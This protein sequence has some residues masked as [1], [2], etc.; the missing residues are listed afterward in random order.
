MASLVKQT[1]YAIDPKTGEK[2]AKKSQC[3]Y[4]QYRDSDGKWVR[5]KAHKDKAASQT[6]L[7]KIVQEAERGNYD[8][9]LKHSRRPL[10]EHLQDFKQALANSGTAKNAELKTARIQRILDAGKI[11]YIKDLSASAVQET[12]SSF[13]KIVANYRSGRRKETVLPDL[14]S[15]KSKSHYLKAIK[16]FCCWLVK[17]RRAAENPLAY[18]TSGRIIPTQPRRAMTADQVGRLLQSTEAARDWRG[19]SGPERAMLYRLAVETGL[20]S[21]EL[22]SLTVGDF[23]LSANVVRLAGKFAKNRNDVALPLR[24]ATVEKLKTFFAGKLPGAAVFTM[25]PSEI[26]SAMIQS[27]LR[28]AGIDP[29]DDGTGKLDFHALRHTFATLLIQTGVDIKS[30]QTLLRHSSP[31]MT[32][33]VY[34]HRIRGAETAAIAA[35]PDFENIP[36]AEQQRKTGT[37]DLAPEKTGKI[38][39]QKHTQKSDFSCLL[40][41]KVV[42]GD[43][44]NPDIKEGVK[45]ALEGPKTA[46]LEQKQGRVETT[47]PCTEFDKWSAPRP[48]FIVMSYSDGLSDQP[49]RPMTNR[50]Y[51]HRRCWWISVSGIG[52]PL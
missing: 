38:L 14:I 41:S 2:T 6:L 30:A 22:R 33:K 44:A 47:L 9:Y 51:H 37:D 26:I 4:I 50:M 28:A 11:F 16:Q 15:S 25:P 43:K 40:E 42:Y 20:R 3:W 13:R 49:T 5:M 35:L 31:A 10:A 8:K 27:D 52:H 17:D 21:K 46:I 34:T 12:I 32:L 24:A 36:A 48:S 18:L 23:D 45:T 39:T 1:Y 29:S 7:G 19:M